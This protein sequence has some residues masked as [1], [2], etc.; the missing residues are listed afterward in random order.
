MVGLWESTYPAV[1]VKQ[2]LL[3]MKAWSISNPKKRKTKAGMMGFVNNWLSKEQDKPAQ[4]SSRQPINKPS[5]FTLANE[6][7]W[8]AYNKEAQA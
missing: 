3:S 5:Q 7:R 6:E 2:Q 8:A 1:N 4:G